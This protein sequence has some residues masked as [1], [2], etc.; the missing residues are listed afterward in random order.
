M[1]NAAI[2]WTP[3]LTNLSRN[4]EEDE[5]LCAAIAPF[6]KVTALEHLLKLPNADE[7]FVI[8]RWLPEEIIRGVSDIDI[9]PLLKKR[10]IPLYIHNAIHLKIF[11]FDSDRAFCSSANVTSMGLG[12]KDQGN[13]EAGALVT[14]QFDDYLELKRLRDDSLL[15]T[16]D[17]Y[18]AY[19]NQLDGIQLPTSTIP[20]VHLPSI[21]DKRFLLSML[22]ATESPDIL[23]QYYSTLGTTQ[24]N[25]DAQHRVVHDLC[26][27]KIPTGLTQNE[28]GQ[29]LRE[30]FRNNPFIL[31]IVGLIKQ[32]GS[33][34][35]GEVNDFIH[36]T[37]RDVPLPYR[38]EIK[39]TTANL[40]NWLAYYYTEIT[41]DRPNY[42][43]VAYW[44]T[45]L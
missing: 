34:R 21:A 23:W 22:P 32:K 37:C 26:N 24:L 36:R 38:W 19:R 43:Q 31:E 13:F 6:M 45:T 17:I 20:K 39:S 18:E 8:T 28:L 16:D 33:I 29:R 4:L 2:I 5:R 12:L 10:G 30:G 15:V 14:L 42:S 9:Y 11:L 44:N 7:I 41:W 27:Y 40:Y 25:K 35:F 1:N 3:I